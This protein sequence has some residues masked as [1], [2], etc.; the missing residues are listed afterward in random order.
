[1][2]AK[3]VQEKE[4]SAQ[5]EG[6]DGAC[7]WTREGRELLWLSELLSNGS[8]QRRGWRFEK[9]NFLSFPRS[10]GPWGREELCL[11]PAVSRSFLWF[12]TSSS[13]LWVGHSPEKEGF[14][15]DLCKSFFHPIPSP[16]SLTKASSSC[17]VS[18]FLTF[19]KRRL[20]LSW[21]T[22]S[23]ASH[24]SFLLWASFVRCQRGFVLVAT[25]TRNSRAIIW[26]PKKRNRYNYPL[27]P[28]P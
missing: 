10:L 22:P 21:R 17:I 20:P 28:K 16:L 24:P 26:G 8:C 18:T 2:R 14:S 23:R 1:M 11:W 4:R 12:V 7:G 5:M 13:V 6:S 27:S 15:N 9:R 3:A 19:L 25:P